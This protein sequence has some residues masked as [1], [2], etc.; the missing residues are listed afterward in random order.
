MGY[1]FGESDPYV[2]D[3]EWELD[4]LIKLIDDGKSP[5]YIGH[6]VYSAA[7]SIKRLLGEEL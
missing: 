6:Y 3:L 1:A 5:E 7:P 4:Q 2:S